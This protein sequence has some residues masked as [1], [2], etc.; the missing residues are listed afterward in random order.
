MAD[1]LENKVVEEVETAKEAVEE[2]VEDVKE[3]A[4]DVAEAAEEK[5]E[6]AVGKTKSFAKKWAIDVI[7][8]LALLAIMIFM[9]KGVPAMMGGRHDAHGNKV[10][11]EVPTYSTVQMLE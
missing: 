5:A 4:A 8:I 11:M 6:K 3:A 2:K 1:N 9:V 7:A 10:L